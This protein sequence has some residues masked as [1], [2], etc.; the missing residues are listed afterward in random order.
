MSLYHNLGNGKF[1]DVTVKAGLDPKMHAIVCT[2]GDY[3]ND[4]FVDLAV[5]P[6]RP[7]AVL[8][9]ERNGTFKDVD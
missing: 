7:R 8:H 6:E 9:N 1:E 4:G 3:D 2:S 5:S